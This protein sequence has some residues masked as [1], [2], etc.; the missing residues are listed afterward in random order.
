[1]LAKDVVIHNCCEPLVELERIICI[2]INLL[3]E[4]LTR[5]RDFFLHIGGFST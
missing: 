3:V 2:P 1:M 5:F 4:D